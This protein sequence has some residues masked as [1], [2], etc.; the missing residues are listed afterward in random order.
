MTSSAGPEGDFQEHCVH[1]QLFASF[2]LRMFPLLD[3][4]QTVFL[5][6]EAGSTTE[7]TNFVFL[8][9]SHEYDIICSVGMFRP[10][11]IVFSFQREREKSFSLDLSIF[12]NLCFFWLMIFSILGDVSPFLCFVSPFWT[13]ASQTSPRHQTPQPRALCQSL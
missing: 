13:W 2:L 3:S 9:L 4:G 8:P 12:V 1:G 5:L 11:L 6:T 7:G 10:L